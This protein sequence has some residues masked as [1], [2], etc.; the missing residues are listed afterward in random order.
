MGIYRELSHAIYYIRDGVELAYY[1]YHNNVIEG[2]PEKDGEIITKLEM[3]NNIDDVERFNRN[4]AQGSWDVTPAELDL[5]DNYKNEITWPAVDQIKQ[6]IEIGNLSWEL[7]YSTIT[8]QYTLTRTIF[9][10]EW[11][12]YLWFCSCWKKFVGDVK[13]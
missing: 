3:Q 7:K 2:R 12:D 1:R 13:A 10:L 5:S 11:S 9:D 4:L 8:K 6:I